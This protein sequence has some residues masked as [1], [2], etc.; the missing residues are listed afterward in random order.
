MTSLSRDLQSPFV[1]R[2]VFPRMNTSLMFQLAPKQDRPTRK[3]RSTLQQALWANFARQCVPWNI[4]R[5]PR[6]RDFFFTLSHPSRLTL[7]AKHFKAL[8]C[9]HVVSSSGPI[10]NEYAPRK[11]VNPTTGHQYTKRGED[12]A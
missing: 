10:V 4:I 11:V 9:R 6:Q 5:I 3:T 7:G 12:I 8:A 1:R 2:G